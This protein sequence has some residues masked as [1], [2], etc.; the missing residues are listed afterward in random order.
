MF[1]FEQADSLDRCASVFP[2]EIHWDFLQCVHLVYK[3]WLVMQVLSQAWHGQRPRQR[4]ALFA[5]SSLLSAASRERR[6]L[7]GSMLGEA[8]ATASAD[9]HRKAQCGLG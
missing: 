6:P 1:I 2:C 5:S 7:R 3:A 4:Q 9:K 8:D